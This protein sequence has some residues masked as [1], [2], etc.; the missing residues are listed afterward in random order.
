M[1]AGSDFA[2]SLF[3]FLHI[4]LFIPPQEKA[5]LTL[6]LSEGRRKNLQSVPRS[7]RLWQGWPLLLFLLCH[8]VCPDMENLVVG[9]QVADGQHAEILARHG[10]RHADLVAVFQWKTAIQHAAWS[11]LFNTFLI[12]SSF[13]YQSWQQNLAIRNLIIRQSRHKNSFWEKT[14]VL[15]KKNK[16]HC[17][18]VTVADR[19]IFLLW[20]S[21]S[22]LFYFSLH[23]KSIMALQGAGQYVKLLRIALK[24]CEEHLSVF[25]LS[26]LALQTPTSIICELNFSS[27]LT[28]QCAGLPKRNKPLLPKEKTL[29]SSGTCRCFSGSPDQLPPTLA[30]E[31]ECT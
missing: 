14:P 3:K 13:R 23:A 18:N 25:L 22:F 21:T 27:L 9:R 12:L 20:D 8:V 11:L 15:H 28:L 19:S 31:L 1:W 26:V 17:K 16:S 4:P 29:L 6:H 5:L 2:G 24:T 7:A 10:R 30:S